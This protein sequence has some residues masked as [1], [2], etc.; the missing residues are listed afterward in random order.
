[1]AWKW[2]PKQTSILL[3]ALLNISPGGA[4]SSH[5]P[6][7]LLSR[8]RSSF[9]WTP[10]SVWQSGAETTSSWLSWALPSCNF[11]SPCSH[12]TF[13]FLEAEDG[14][15]S[16]RLPGRMNNRP[17]LPESEGFPRTWDFLKPG[18]SP[19]NQKCWSPYSQNWGGWGHDQCWLS[20]WRSPCHSSTKV[21]WKFPGSH[22]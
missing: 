19:E 10:S 20:C 17:G 22:L 8:N 6:F 21:S 11:P 5:Q 9:V 7:L 16:N 18:Q 3:N 1:M 2:A 14:K 15:Q 12:F 4:N 13:S